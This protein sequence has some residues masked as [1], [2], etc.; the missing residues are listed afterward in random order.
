MPPCCNAIVDSRGMS[1]GGLS[2]GHAG[3][4]LSSGTL[5]LEEFVRQDD[6][7]VFGADVN[8]SSSDQKPLPDLRGMNHLVKLNVTNTFQSIPELRL[9]LDALDMTNTGRLRPQWDTYFMAWD[10]CRRALPKLTVSGSQTLAELAS[11]RSNCMKRRVGA[12]LVRDNRI[13]A[14]G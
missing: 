5:S 13:V 11:Q 9:H 1:R 7:C 4:N 10:V 14:T 6:E 8:S 2:L 3:N 12:I